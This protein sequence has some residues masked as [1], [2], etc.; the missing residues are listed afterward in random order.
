MT[1]SRP[2]GWAV[3]NL[4]IDKETTLYK[5]FMVAVDRRAHP[6]APTRQQ[7]LERGLRLA[8][9]EIELDKGPRR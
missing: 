6:L 2:T 1:A 7:I 4:R 5:R 8:L 3:F 9:D